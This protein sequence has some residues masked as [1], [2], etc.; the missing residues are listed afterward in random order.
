MNKGRLFATIWDDKNIF[1]IISETEEQ[2]IILLDKKSCYS[3]YKKNP[4]IFDSDSKKEIFDRY[5]G[6]HEIKDVVEKEFVFVLFQ[7]LN[8][9]QGLLPLF[10]TGYRELPK[11]KAFV[12]QKS[13]GK[14]VSIFEFEQI[15]E[16][17]K[18]IVQIKKYETAREKLINILRHLENDEELP[19][20]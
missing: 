1:Y 2:A 7:A 12:E 4:K 5:N 9:E 15:K 14:I 18:K 11:L 3:E 13:N 8:L 10:Q 16:F 20:I 17:E 19:L 6:L